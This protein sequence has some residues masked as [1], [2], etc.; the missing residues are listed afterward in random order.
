MPLLLAGEGNRHCIDAH[1]W[2]APNPAFSPPRVGHEMSH[3]GAPEKAKKCRQLRYDD[4][5]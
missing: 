3:L 2:P 1:E 4:Y 5:V